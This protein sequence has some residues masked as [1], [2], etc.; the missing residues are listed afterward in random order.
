MIPFKKEKRNGRHWVKVYIFPEG[1]FTAKEL[2]EKSGLDET[3]IHKRAQT[4]TKLTGIV[5]PPRPSGPIK[6]QG[7][8]KYSPW[9]KWTDQFYERKESLQRYRER[10][11]S[12]EDE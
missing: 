10:M 3:T 2:A 4:C 1:E 6:P 11:R 8:G 9:S 12:I 5:A 7:H